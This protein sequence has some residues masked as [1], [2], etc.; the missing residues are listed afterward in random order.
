MRK[1]IQRDDYEIFV[2]QADGKD[3]DFWLKFGPLATSQDAHKTLGGAV[4]DSDDHTWL[5]AVKNGRAVAI[6]SYS[7]NGNVAH[8]NETYVVPNERGNGLYPLLFDLKY[9]LCRSD[10][11][12]VVKGLANGRGRPLF[13]KRGW[14]VCR[15]T[16]NWTWF[17]KVVE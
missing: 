9:D 11:V 3:S 10:G 8:F 4:V 7:K 12:T 5:L 1:I 13:E 6:S 2:A 17:Q 16:K 15:Q 14:E